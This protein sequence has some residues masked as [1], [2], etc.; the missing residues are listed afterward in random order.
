MPNKRKSEGNERVLRSNSDLSGESDLDLPIGNKNKKSKKDKGNRKDLEHKADKRTIKK[1]KKKAKDQQN[2][3]TRFVED[4]QIM[5]MAVEIHTNDSEEDEYKITETESE[6]E[7]RNNIKESDSEEV[8]SSTEEG[9]IETDDKMMQDVEIL[10]NFDRQTNERHDKQSTV[11]KETTLNSDAERIKQID[12]EMHEKL[13]E[14]H[15]MMKKGGLEESAKILQQLPQIQN[16]KKELSKGNTT[17]T[18]KENTDLLPINS[19]QDNN[20]SNANASTKIEG[21]VDVILPNNAKSLETI[22]DAAVP[23]RGSSSSEEELMLNSSNES[24]QE[25][26]NTSKANHIEVFIAEASKQCDMNRDLPV[27]KAAA[28]VHSRIATREEMTGQP[29]PQLDQPSTSTG[30]GMKGRFEDD[31]GTVA[32][33][34]ITDAERAKARIF[35]T[36]GNNQM[37]DFDRFANH[38]QMGND[39]MFNEP[40]QNP[41][42]H[43]GRVAL[44]PSAIV[45]EGYIV[46][47]AHLDESMVS[48]IEKGEY[49]D[50]GKL[51]P[52]D[53]ATTSPEEDGRIELVVRNGRTF[54][55]PV[56]VSININSFARWE[57]AFRVFSNIYCKT[58]PHRSAELIEYNYV[59][60]TIAM[61]YVWDNVYTY[62]K[63][64]RL[65]MARNPQ[66]SWAM[67]LQQAWLLRLRDRISHNGQNWSSGTP[68]NN[69]GGNGN[70]FMQG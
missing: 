67:I 30:R 61:S 26:S 7:N 35:A 4:N 15:N 1:V 59:I 28:T 51:L 41:N 32:Q 8:D 40:N 23:K 31:P 16:N 14:L 12:R 66:R 69:R 2:V 54:W 17:V 9:Q 58:N 3:D 34:M 70:G 47:G 11:A 65:H 19:E 68:P 44:T 57:Q 60:H 49:V 39:T 56:S 48:K 36:Q 29:I 63:E 43:E 25:I 50:F 62:D 21:I 20:N 55:S 6:T 46:V 37:G 13:L 5:E 33:R 52:K 38:Q 42:F 45:D 18:F 24:A 64:F 22:Y 10:F 53:R 27:N